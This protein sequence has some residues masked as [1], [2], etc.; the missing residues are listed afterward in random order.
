MTVSPRLRREL[1]QR[2]SSIEKMEKVALPAISFY[3]LRELLRDL[4]SF[5]KLEDISESCAF[6]NYVRDQEAK[7]HMSI[8]V[9]SK[10]AESKCFAHQHGS[11]FQ[12]THLCI[13]VFFHR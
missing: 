3:S 8:G 10:E 2:Y 6:M 12:W 5:V 7:S 11:V 4:L 1:A 13:T 9:D